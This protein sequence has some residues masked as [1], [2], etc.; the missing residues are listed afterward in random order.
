MC[1]ASKVRCDKQKPICSRCER[2]GY[3]C[4]FS[5]ARRVRKRRY[6]QHI[7]SE[8]STEAAEVATGPPSNPLS[9]NSSNVES[10]NLSDGTNA[11][12]S[13]D[14]SKRADAF[15][16]A[17]GN[18]QRRPDLPMPMSAEV[19]NIGIELHSIESDYSPSSVNSDSDCAAI[20]IGLLEELNMANGVRLTDLFSL[21][22]SESDNV[23]NLFDKTSLAIK[24]VSTMLVC[25]CSEK[26]EVGLLAATICAALLDTYEVILRDCIQA[27]DTSCQAQSQRGA[28]AHRARKV[29][30]HTDGSES[31]S[32]TCMNGFKGKSAT[33]RLLGT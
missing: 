20:A 13:R 16:S 17:A 4:F 26:T 12:K 24:R 6:T 30:S 31:R 5:P 9:R 18:S 3:P 32:T 14:T 25:P 1:S 28:K 29:L 19:G 8:S 27:E 11:S 10:M 21:D 33:M 2:L 7:S 22:G 15:E 23:D